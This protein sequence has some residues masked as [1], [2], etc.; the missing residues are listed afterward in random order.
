MKCVIKTL[1]GKLQKCN[2]NILQNNDTFDL[3][4]ECNKFVNIFLITPT[5]FS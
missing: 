3:T 2:M 4:C 5:N 1:F